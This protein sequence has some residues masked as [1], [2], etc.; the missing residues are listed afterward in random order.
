MRGSILLLGAAV[1][2]CDVRSQSTPLEH[3]VPFACE[4]DRDCSV[5]RCLAE[6]GI[7]S[8]PSGQVTTLLFEVTPQASDPVYGGAR[9]L[10][11]VRIDGTDTP[12]SWLELNVR[13]RVP[14]SGSVV[15]AQS[16]CLP[17]AG[18]TLPVTLTFT[19]RE[20]LI[21]LSVPS[22]Q[23]STATF[24]DVNNV[25][26]FEGSLPPGRYDVYM[27]PPSSP[28]WAKTVEPSRRSLETS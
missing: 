21:G 18:N 13:P 9:F 27:N 17:F 24:D 5:G 10:K 22:Y 8:R 16:E 1:V 23:L 25:Y 7:C 15:T 26:R 19:P 2:A 20:R 12:G 14:V 28:T 4:A 11:E 6:F 3:D